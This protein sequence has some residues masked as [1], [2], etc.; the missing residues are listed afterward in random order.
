[1][2]FLGPV[3]SNSY[4]AAAAKLFIIGLLSEKWLQKVEIGEHIYAKNEFFE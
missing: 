4:S 3:T 1:M 2:E